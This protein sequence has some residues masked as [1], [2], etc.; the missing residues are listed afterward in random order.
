MA[1]EEFGIAGTDFLGSM[2]RLLLGHAKDEIRSQASGSTGEF[3]QVGGGLAK[4]EIPS[5]AAGLTGGSP[6]VD[7]GVAKDEI[8]GVSG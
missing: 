7:P 2:G 8:R 4:D 6:Q 1:Q 3:R 5:Q